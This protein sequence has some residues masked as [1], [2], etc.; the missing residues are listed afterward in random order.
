MDELERFIDEIDKLDEE[1]K[2]KEARAVSFID[3]LADEL[4]TIALSS[5]EEMETL[6][7]EKR[8][9]LAY[10]AF[11]RAKQ[12][13]EFMFE[14]IYKGVDDMDEDPG[15]FVVKPRNDEDGNKH[16][17]EE[18]LKALPVEF[19]EA[20]IEAVNEG[21]EADKPYRDFLYDCFEC[22]KRALWVGFPEISELTGNS[23]LH[24]NWQVYN[25]MWYFAN[26]LYEIVG[27]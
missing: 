11:Y 5:F 16:K 27:L 18:Q 23:I 24:M 17:L 26:D 4:M 22:A 21:I 9:K 19:H 1:I 2:K 25:R 7:P 13:N 15:Q 3:P 8:E 6:E 20:Y 12:L 10:Q 14:R